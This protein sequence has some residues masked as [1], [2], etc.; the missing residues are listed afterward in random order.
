MTTETS[1]LGGMLEGGLWRNMSSEVK[2]AVTAAVVPRVLKPGDVLFAEGA[3]ATGMF[4]VEQGSVALFVRDP[5]LGLRVELR[6]ATVGEAF[7]EAGLFAGERWSMGAEALEHT[8]VQELSR[9]AFEKITATEPAVGVQVAAALAR[10][11]GEVLRQRRVAAGVLRNLSVPDEVKALIPLA[12]V[13]RHRMTAIAASGDT[14]TVACVDPDNRVGID[15]VTRLV[16]GQHVRILAV[17]PDDF[18]RYVQTQLSALPARPTPAKTTQRPRA[19]IQFIGVDEPRSTSGL[20]VPDVV[21]LWNQI[22]VEGI[23]RGASDIHVEPERSMISVRYRVDGRLVARQGELPSGL[24]AP[25]VNRTKVLAGIDIAE[26]RK[27]QE[28]RISLRVGHRAYD[29]RLATVNTKWGEKLV[30]RVLD[31]SSLQVELAAL[32]LSPGMCGAVRDLFKKSNGLVLVTGPTGCGK[33]TT[34]YAALAERRNPETSIVTIEDPI[35]YTMDQVTQVQVNEGIGVDFADVL[36]TYLR[37]DPNVILVG[38]SRDGKTARLACTAALS[39][40]LVL[41]SFH[42]NDAPAAIQRLRALEVENYLIADSLLGV[43]NQR[44]VRRVCPECGRE[45]SLHDAEREDLMRVGVVLDTEVVVARGTGCGRCNGEGYTGRAAVF[46]LLVNSPPVRD[47]IARGVAAQ[48][49]RRLAAGAYVPFSR[50]ATFLL[51]SGVTTPAELVRAL[52]RAD[53]PP[54][55]GEDSRSKSTRRRGGAR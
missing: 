41:S 12:V 50:Y 51:E 14:V 49:L 53:V 35:E 43:I 29:L 32:V 33:T 23:E 39:G 37:Q 2:A 55:S 25:L 31:P 30:M 21:E 18:A 24:L 8:R 42:T 13:H 28:G 47:A 4:M 38:E 22:V 52:P 15:E 20:G 34:L 19:P 10:Q 9:I 40:H 44:L 16:R 46:E 11:L 54:E 5:Q 3:E 45:G 26:R 7:G 48:E 27:P 17:S 6:C 1:S 36:R